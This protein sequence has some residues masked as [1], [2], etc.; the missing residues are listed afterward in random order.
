MTR[1]KITILALIVSLIGVLIAIQPQSQIVSAQESI[2]EECAAPSWQGQMFA[3][4]DFSGSPS[5]TLCRRIIHFDWGGGMPM[6]GVGPDNFSSR[7]NT[8]YTFPAA[9]KYLFTVGVSGGVRL[10]VNNEVL[11]DSMENIPGFR[12]LSAEYN[13]PAAGAPVPIMIEGAHWTG[14]D[15]ALHFNWFLTEGG[16]PGA[17]EDHSQI[18]SS[19]PNAFA[20]DGGN[21]WTVEHW[22]NFELSGE[23]VALDIHVADGISYDYGPWAP[24]AGMDADVWASRW[25]RTVDF[26]AGTYTFTLV[27]ED[28]G[29]VFVDGQEI[30]FHP[31]RVPEQVFTGTV[32]L[33]EG[34][35]TI[36]VEHI[37]VR[38]DEYIFF[39]WDPPVGT[40]LWPDGC[41][42]HFTHGIAPN[43][44][45]CPNRGPATIN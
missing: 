23:P 16:S 29:R 13:I 45:L 21:V 25:T 3:N 31:T 5:H 18:F 27:V 22:Q 35:H 15:K 10:T 36:V 38:W 20:V 4:A 43:A 19:G 32:T 34:R 12:S 44:P 40:M 2:F 14:E 9:G 30:I 8:T 6:A 39:T 42:S 26:P 37:D 28:Q 1:N 7:W 24:A 17:V 33:T 11:I 41:N